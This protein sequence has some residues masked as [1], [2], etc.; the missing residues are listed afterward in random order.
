MSAGAPNVRYRL[1]KF[2][3]RNRVAVSVSAGILF[4]LVAGIVVS[5]WQAV[6]AIS[7]EHLADGATTLLLPNNSAAAKRPVLRLPRVSTASGT[8]FFP[9][10]TRA[11]PVQ[12]QTSLL[13]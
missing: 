3:R 2:L 12:R 8:G 4:L 6:R 5:T 13:R 10:A 9:V 7:A 11:T 1:G